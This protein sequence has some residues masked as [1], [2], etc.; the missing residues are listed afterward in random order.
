MDLHILKVDLDY[1]YLENVINTM[2]IR[3]AYINDIGFLPFKHIDKIEANFKNSWNVKIYL[4]KDLREDIILILQC[5]LG[6]DWR[7]EINTALNHYC[8]KMEYSNR[9]FDYKNYGRLG[10][11][12]CRT[13][14]I[15]DQVKYKVLDKSRKL[16]YN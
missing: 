8:L 1:Y 3:L 7:K 12:K 10:F 2:F 5:C 14:N 13:I 11:K 4:K 15:Y 6:S 9:M 16:Y